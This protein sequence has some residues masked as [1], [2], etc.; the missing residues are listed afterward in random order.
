MNEVKKSLKIKVL[1]IDGTSASVTPVTFFHS[2]SIYR[3]DTNEFRT[4]LIRDF[5]RESPFYFDYIKQ[6]LHNS[7]NFC[8]RLPVFI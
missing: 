4:F 3:N 7:Y 6:F 8:H 5:G 1:V 2:S